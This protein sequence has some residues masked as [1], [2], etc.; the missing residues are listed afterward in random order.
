MRPL[1]DTLYAPLLPE[2]AAAVL[3]M[4]S[5]TVI[6]AP[7]SALPIAT[8]PLIE[9]AAVALDE[10]DEPEPDPPPPHAVSIAVAAIHSVNRAIPEVPFFFILLFLLKWR[11]SNETRMSTCRA[12]F[13]IRLFVPCSACSTENSRTTGGVQH[14]HLALYRLRNVLLKSQCF[15][16]ERIS[17]IWSKSSGIPSRWIAKCSIK[18]QSRQVIVWIV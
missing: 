11:V 4:A 18:C 13:G 8:V 5:M 3:P 14:A 17:R 10:P 7:T 2:V 1:I 15:N 9:L 12:D 16:K 6:G